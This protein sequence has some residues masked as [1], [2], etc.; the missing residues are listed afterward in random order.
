VS[1]GPL[2][3]S[4]IARQGGPEQ[5]SF[6]REE[7]NTEADTCE[8]CEVSYHR[9]CLEEFGRTCPTP[10]CGAEVQGSGP[11]A[12]PSISVHET[13]RPPNSSQP[14]TGSGFPS[15]DVWAWTGLAWIV[16]AVGYLIADPQLLVHVQT[17]WVR[18]FL[19]GVPLWVVVAW[20]I[21]AALDK[22]E[23]ANSSAG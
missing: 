6:C 17:H 8:G 15:T 9:A 4:V 3:V 21:Q 23:S 14:A 19:V 5:C 22:R 16:P 2:D 10:G 20:L 13:L 18:I 1:E 12:E 11:V 7:V